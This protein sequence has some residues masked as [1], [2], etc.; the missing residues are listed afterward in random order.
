MG[1]ARKWF[2]LSSSRK[3][4]I[5][6]AILILV[7][8]YL[9]WP[10]LQYTHESRSWCLSWVGHCAIHSLWS[11]CYYPILQQVKVGNEGGE[12]LCPKLAGD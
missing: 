3:E 10:D 4:P 5:P 11:A 1:K 2:L 6:A 9:R 12:I 7:W 8:W